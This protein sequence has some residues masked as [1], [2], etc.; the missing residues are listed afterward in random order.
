[1]NDF[2]ELNELNSIDE[3]RENIDR[4]A[5]QKTDEKLELGDI[6]DFKGFYVALKQGICAIWRRH[7]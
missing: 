5:D 6:H 7:N 1:M 4:V 2:T 3:E